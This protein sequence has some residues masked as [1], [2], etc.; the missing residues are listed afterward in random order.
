M[1][2]S[3]EKA[4]QNKIDEINYVSSKAKI[5]A[6]LEK[7]L[8]L[9]IK[10]KISEPNVERNT[11]SSSFSVNRKCDFYLDFYFPYDLSVKIGLTFDIKEND[12]LR[13]EQIFQKLNKDF[14]DEI[15]LFKN[16]RKAF[17]ESSFPFLIKQGRDWFSDLRED[18]SAKLPID[19]V[20]KLLKS[21]FES[22]KFSTEYEISKLPEVVKII[23]F[24]SNLLKSSQFNNKLPSKINSNYQPTMI[25]FIIKTK[26]SKIKIKKYSTFYPNPFYNKFE[27]EL[28]DFL[29][30]IEEIKKSEKDLKLEEIKMF[31]PKG[32]VIDND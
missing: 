8:Q 32:F 28:V 11:P 24:Q 21:I 19:Y 1:D 13:I 27:N 20:E 17:E 10:V 22:Y 12:L 14:L 2:E 29:Q 3:L 5:E 7:Y 23:S 6:I 31:W 16:S 9:P 26:N 4:K 18:S 15:E 25:K 30:R